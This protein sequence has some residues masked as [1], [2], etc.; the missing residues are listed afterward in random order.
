L[1]PDMPLGM[2]YSEN[3][4]DP[5]GMARAIGA[6]ALHPNWEWVNPGLVQN[7]HTAGLQV[8]TWT[9]NIPLVLDLVKYCGVDG[10]MSDFPDRI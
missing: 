1:D 10:I 4:L 2:L 6:T 8:N 7:A 5:V 9:V 3:L